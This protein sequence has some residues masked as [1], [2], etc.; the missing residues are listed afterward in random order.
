MKKIFISAGLAAVSAAGF[1]T[2]FAAGPD[3]LSPKDWNVSG[4]LRGFY[5]DNYAAGG[6]QKGSFGLEV[7]PTISLNVPLQQ[8]E[9]GLRYTYGLYYYQQRQDLGVD[10]FDQTHQMELWLDHAFNE[11]WRANASDSFAIGQEPELLNPGISATPYR[12]EG[13][14]IANHANLTLNTEW[15]RQFSTKLHYGNNFYDYQNSGGNA[16]VP[17]YAGL[18]NRIEQNVSL[19]FQWTIEP[20]T[21]AFI[22]YN[23]SLVNYTGD[24]PIAVYNQRSLVYMSDSRDSMEHTAYVGVNHQFTANVSG[25]MRGGVTYT[26]SYNDPLQETTSVSP[27]ADM[28]VSYTYM[29]GSYLQVGLTHE[30]NA[31]DVVQLGDNGSLTQNQESTVIYAD[32]NHR[33]T[34]KLLGTVIGRFS[35]STFNGGAYN[36]SSDEAYSLGI[37]LNYQINRHFSTDLGYNYDDLVSGIAGRSY[38]RNRVYIGLTAN[39]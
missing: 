26:D 28:S 29:P 17:S 10:A 14:N 24:E 21:I 9:I 38:D 27:Y 19:D 6:N 3:V 22:G 34:P 25:M 20:E 15:T 35:S 33:F 31:T 32:V 5:D 11:R 8:T 39:Y 23:F 2:V 1:E 4:T 7:S 13:D 18:L 30:I 16:I 36:N 12:I 37:N